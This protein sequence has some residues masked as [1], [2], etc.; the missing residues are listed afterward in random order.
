MVR[1]SVMVLSQPFAF[2]LIC[3]YVPD[4]VYVLPFNV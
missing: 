1:S 4:V 2:G 3:V